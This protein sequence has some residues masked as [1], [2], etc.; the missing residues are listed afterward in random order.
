MKHD[1]F[2]VCEWCGAHLDP[3]EKCDCRGDDRKEGEPSL[4]PAGADRDEHDK[5]DRVT[6]A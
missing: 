6:A 5:K 1:Y 3:G 4:F 2:K